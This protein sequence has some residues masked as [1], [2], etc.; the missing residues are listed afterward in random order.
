M[1]IPNDRLYA[2]LPAI[3]RIRDAERGEPLRA[4][5]SIIAE[6]VEVVE[7]DIDQLYDNWFIETCQDWIVPYLADL[8]GY[9]PV[10]EAGEPGDIATPQARLRNAILISRREVANTLRN[11]RRKGTLALLELLANDVAG[12]PARAMEFYTVLGRT[13]H[14]KHVRWQRGRTVDLRQG[15]VLD[16]LDTPFDALAHTIDVRRIHSPYRQGRYNIP[17]VGLFVW[18]LKSYSVTHTPAYCVEEIGPHC[19]TFSV[20]GNDSPLYNKPEAEIEPTHIAEALNLPTPIARRAFEETINGADDVAHHQAAAAYYGEG[21]SLVIY[22]PDWPKKGMSLDQAIPRESI[23]PANLDQW[24]Y[25]APRNHIVVDPERGRIVFP[26]GQLPKKGVWVSY[27]YALSGD[28]GGGE[29]ERPL[30]Q[31]VDCVVIQVSGQEQ[32]KM[33]LAPWTDEELSKDPPVEQPAHAVIEITDSGVYAQPLKLTLGENHS[34]QIRAANR[35]RP[36]IRLLDWQTDRSDALTVQGAAGSHFTLDGLL[37]TGRGMQVEG[38]LS[39]LTIRHSTLVPGWGLE[40]DCAAKRP[41]E[42]SLELFV[43]QTRVEIEHSILGSIQVSHDEVA[44]DPVVIHISD[45]IVDATC[46]DGDTSCDTPECEALSAPLCGI[47]HAQLTIHRSTVF[48][49]ID[50]HAIALAENTLFNGV[51]NVARRQYGCMRFCYVPPASRTPRRYHCQPDLVEQAA[52]Q[53]Q[54]LQAEGQAVSADK[55][56]AEIAVAQQRERERVRPRFNSERYGTPQYCQLAHACADEIKRGAEDESEMGVFH[57]LFQPQRAAN[58]R[59]R[60]DEYTPAGMSAG[61]TYAN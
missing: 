38:E 40:C 27:R 35:T 24:H 55:L 53:T 8:I 15:E 19:F 12:W 17:N 50:T 18:R 20:L 39:C 9:Q 16:R 43:T 37:I 5:L 49:R 6:Q 58:L 61:I 14:L 29:Y 4:L 3:Y 57:D 10:H 1:S 56:A 46:S 22:A 42:P 30:A 34:L 2:L 48:G 31:P 26:A 33:A 45:S 25:R 44:Q 54:R 21:K 36:V 59:A 32:L 60:L 11:R 51:V 23:I 7:K 47:A 52:E 28:I 41:T 13:Q